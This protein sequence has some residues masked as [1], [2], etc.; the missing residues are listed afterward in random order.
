M[1]TESFTVSYFTT[2]SRSDG[3]K[4]GM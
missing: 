2:E 4:K 3:E 1:Q